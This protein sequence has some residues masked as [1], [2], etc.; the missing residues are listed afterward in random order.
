LALGELLPD[1]QP[2]KEILLRTGIEGDILDFCRE[3]T[4][5]DSGIG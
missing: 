3:E 1:I 4:V 5:K 2:G